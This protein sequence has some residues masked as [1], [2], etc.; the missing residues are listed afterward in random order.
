MEMYVELRFKWNYVNLY[1]LLNL[2]NY[3]Y[4]I[5]PYG[6]WMVGNT[7]GVDYGGILN[8]GSE[9][10]PECTSTAFTIYRRNCNVHK[11]P[12]II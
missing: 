9:S 5:N 7:V 6:P 4:W 12:L 3:L 1:W 2:Q 8:R 10:C 11:I